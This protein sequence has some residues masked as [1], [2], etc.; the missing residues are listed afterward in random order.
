MLKFVSFAFNYERG[1]FMATMTFGT[2]KSKLITLL[3]KFNRKNIY[4]KKMYII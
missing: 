1:L 3:A 4:K 2:K